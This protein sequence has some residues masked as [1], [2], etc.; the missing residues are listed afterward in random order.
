MSLKHGISSYLI[1]GGGTVS[2]AVVNANA[3]EALT[4]TTKQIVDTATPDAQWILDAFP[5]YVD[6]GIL[7]IHE[8]HIYVDG[9]SLT[10]IASMTVASLSLVFLLIRGLSDLNLYLLNRRLAL[11][12]LT[13]AGK[14]KR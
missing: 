1:Y 7:A 13:M 14:K 4:N 6:S 11:K 5:S 12:Q 3:P 9:L 2:G 8:G 10:D